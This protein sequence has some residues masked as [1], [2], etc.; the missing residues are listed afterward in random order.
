MYDYV[1][2]Y[3]TRIFAYPHYILPLAPDKL[4]MNQ[5]NK[6][7]LARIERRPVIKRAQHLIKGHELVSTN[8]F[9]L[10]KCSY[11]H[12]MIINTSGYQCKR[13]I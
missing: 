10:L 8:F 12:E 13:K 6:E 9:Q 1:S 2:S 5:L 4:K 7:M 11:C 3:R